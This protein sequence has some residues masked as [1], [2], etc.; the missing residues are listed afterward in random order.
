MKQKAE[1]VLEALRNKNYTVCTA[2]SCTGGLISKTLTDV[3]G[4]SDV[5][6][7][8]VVSYSN[9]VKEKVLGVKGQ[10]LERYGAVSEE[11][12]REM[13]IGAARL[14]GADVAVSVTGIAG[15]GGGSDEKPVGTVCFGLYVK[16]EVETTTKHFDPALSR[17][18][19]R[20]E[21]LFYALELILLGCKG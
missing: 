8:G 10:T 3:A 5:V 12:A 1:A 21:T 13:C 9:E 20:E 15:P 2:E 17:A 7:G 19:I 16:G 14:C 11:T 4:C 6:V 18:E